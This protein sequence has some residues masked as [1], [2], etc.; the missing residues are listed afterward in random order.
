M[1]IFRIIMMQ[2]WCMHISTFFFPNQLPQSNKIHISLTVYFLFTRNF[3]VTTIPDICDCYKMF[4]FFNEI[5]TKRLPY[6]RLYAGTGSQ[7]S[8]ETNIMPNQNTKCF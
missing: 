7:F 3:A 6:G 4:R 2:C 8:H 1:K 5:Q